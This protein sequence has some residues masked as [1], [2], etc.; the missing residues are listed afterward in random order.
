[1]HQP[2]ELGTLTTIEAEAAF[3]FQVISTTK[4]PDGMGYA[5]SKIEQG[6]TD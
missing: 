1:M 5:S 2:T 6:N 3:H 4:Q